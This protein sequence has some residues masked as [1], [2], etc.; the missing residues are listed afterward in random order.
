M[1]KNIILIGS[2][3]PPH[4]GSNI[5]FNSLLKSKINESFNVYHLNTSDHRSLNNLSKL[6]IINV[7]IA[8]KNLI[9]LAFLIN[10]T[11]PHIIYLPHSVF[12]LPFIR[13]GL[14]ILIAHYNSKAKIVT[15]LHGGT[16]F[17]NKFYSSSNKLIRW[18]I[19]STISKVD[20]AIILGNNMKKVYN[21]FKINSCVIPNGTNLFLE[22]FRKRNHKSYITI[23]Y[24]GNFSKNKGILDVFDVMKI[25]LSKNKKIRLEL[26][27][28][29]RSDE[30]QNKKL[31]NDII[32]NFSLD[33]N[34]IFHGK[35]LNNDLKNFYKKIDILL[36]PS[37]NEG[38]PMVIIE[39][40]G[41]E[42]AVVSSK[43]IG[44]IDEVITDGSDGLL[45]EPGNTNQILE[46]LDILINNVKYRKKIAI[47]ARKKYL[48]NYT[49]DR[50]V[51]LMYE[52]FSKI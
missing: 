10:K 40:M 31:I 20:V 25:I 35:L 26:C 37:Y 51:N 47:N 9:Q 13:D 44:A 45:V 11:N 3:P 34:V 19:H 33:E 7:F 4:H 49:L 17:K 15:H 42:C 29:W 48:N 41:A 38:L 12:F 28:E 30:L 23:G 14:L 36:F 46:K 52:L 8:L 16:Y 43:G 27:G 50:N 5:Y 24:V 2:L 6:D 18:F 32:G 22:P 21:H 39:A 1:K